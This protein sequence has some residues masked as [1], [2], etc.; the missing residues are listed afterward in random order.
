MGKTGERKNC[1]QIAHNPGVW[2][3]Q[4]R[5]R[6][7]TGTYLREGLRVIIM[8][9]SHCSTTQNADKR[10]RDTARKKMSRSD[11]V[12]VWFFLNLIR[13]FLYFIFFPPNSP[14]PHYC[15]LN[16]EIKTSPS[17]RISLTI[18]DQS[19]KKSE[20]KVLFCLELNCYFSNDYHCNWS[21]KSIS[22][23]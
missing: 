16:K 11:L 14:H 9:C 19:E 20:K 13:S 18:S 12:W 7:T 3:S 17:L 15:K 5:G 2:P 1:A 4:G 23:L 22:P 8:G 6:T 21:V 10:M